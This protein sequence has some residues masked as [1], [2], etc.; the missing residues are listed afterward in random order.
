[1]VLMAAPSLLCAEMRKL[2]GQ[3]VTRSPSQRNE[4]QQHAL[5]QCIHV[6]LR[7]GTLLTMHGEAR[8]QWTHGIDESSTWMWDGNT[9]PRR[10][11]MSI[12]L[13]RLT[14]EAWTQPG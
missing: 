9:H 4:A 7:P 12:T 11:R 1:M 5:P 6:L 13:R 8:Y 2:S 14:P 10:P 3:P